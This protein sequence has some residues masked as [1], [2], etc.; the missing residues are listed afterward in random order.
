MRTLGQRELEADVHELMMAVDTD[1]SGNISFAE[2]VRFM[3]DRTVSFQT[4]AV[5]VTHIVWVAV[6]HCLSLITL[7]ALHLC[8]VC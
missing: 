2:F 8:S 3:A 5:S 1:N 4:H 6:S 7:S